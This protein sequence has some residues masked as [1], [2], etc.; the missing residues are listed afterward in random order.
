MTVDA[1][2]DR[3]MPSQCDMLGVGPLSPYRIERMGGAMHSGATLG[4]GRPLKKVDVLH[5]TTALIRN[6]LFRKLR[7][8]KGIIC[9][10]MV[11]CE[12]DPPFWLCGGLVLRAADK[13]A[14][15]RQSDVADFRGRYGRTSMPQPTLRGSA[16]SVSHC[17]LSARRYVS[18]FAAMYGF[19]RSASVSSS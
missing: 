17:V 10:S 12:V 4:N 9:N 15:I 5:K 7:V 3:S 8:C 6:V 18:N 1:G 19:S 14:N 13:A 2:F 16:A 11:S